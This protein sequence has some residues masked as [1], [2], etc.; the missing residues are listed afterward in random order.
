MI[1]TTEIARLTGVSQPTVSRVL[2]GNASVNPEAA[3]KVLEC[4]RQYGYQPNMIA[5]GLNG[6][7]TNL[8]AV[9]VPDISNPFFA[10]MIREIEHEAEKNQYTILI[11]NS[12]YNIEKEKKCVRLIQ[13]YHADGLLLAPVRANAK[14]LKDFQK[15]EVPWM[16]FSNCVEGVDSV[17][18]SHRDAGKRVALHLAKTGAEYFFF[19]GEE[20]DPKYVGFR[21]GLME[22]GILVDQKLFRF[23]DRE[24]ERQAKEI[25]REVQERNGRIGIFAIND[26]ELLPVVNALLLAGVRIPEKAALVGFDNTFISRRM[27]PNL[28]SVSQPV[29]EMG[30][31]AVREMIGRICGKKSKPPCHKE[32][33]AELVIRDSSKL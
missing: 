31:Y 13:Q 33:L 11:F 25:V 12:D 3:R 21:E 6:G 22:Q 26:V 8:L 29:E 18:V 20:H 16:V 7:R 1:T 17:F 15:L 4:A 28:S 2:N 23:W 24:K 27:T 10:D 9:V 14:A 32:L 30:K 5:R 19:I